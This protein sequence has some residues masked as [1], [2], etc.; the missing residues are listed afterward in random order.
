[1]SIDMLPDDVLLDIF[2]FFAREVGFT[3][4]QIEEWQ[5]LV[6]V[7]RRWRSLVFGSPRRLDLRLVCSDKT[8]ARDTLDVWPALPLY[9]QRMYMAESVDNIIAVL[10][11]NDRVCNIELADLGRSD[12]EQISAAMQVPFP[13]LTRLL[14]SSNGKPVKRCQPFPICSWVDPPHV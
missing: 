5:T 2:D 14:L 7:C 10:E 13:K 12:L 6:H 11:R 4:E 8:P 9:I 3:K 1:M